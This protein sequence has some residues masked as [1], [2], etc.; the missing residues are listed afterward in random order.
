[1][2]DSNRSTDVPLKLNT[3][4]SLGFN[5]TDETA[6]IASQIVFDDSDAFSV[7]LW[8]RGTDSATNGDWGHALLGRDNIDLYANLALRSGRVE[9]V[10]YNAGW[11]HNIQSTTLVN[12]DQWH[13][14]AY[15]NNANQ[16]GSLYIDG[17]LEIANLSSLIGDNAKFRIDGFMKGFTNQFTSGLI[18]DVRIYNHSLTLAEVE[19]LAII[20]VPEPSTCALVALGVFG[21]AG[22]RRR[23]FLRA[24]K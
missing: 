5:G 1:M 21:F 6:T 8:Y 14:I 24:M 10:H 23:S 18:D 2:N 22:S 11:Q 4:R 19:D 16:T 17:V 3:G 13:H 9:Y 15:V 12:D 7:A 20:P